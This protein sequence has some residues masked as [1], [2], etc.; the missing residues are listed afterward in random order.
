METQRNELLVH[1]IGLETFFDQ[2][3]SMPGG[4]GFDF[5]EPEASACDE[6][7][8]DHESL[9]EYL[10]TILNDEDYDYINADNLQIVRLICSEKVLD[11]SELSPKPS[12]TKARRGH[13]I[14]RS[15]QA[16]G[17]KL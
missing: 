16:K 3:E 5:G 8:E 13:V 4:S 10:D 12:I 11:V 14:L 9:K 7:L 17:M 1:K 2:A 15:I 6:Y